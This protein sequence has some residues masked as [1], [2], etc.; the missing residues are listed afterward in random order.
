[1]LISIIAI[2]LSQSAPDASRLP[3]ALERSVLH[4]LRQ[5]ESGGHPDPA[6][7][8]GDNGR[9]I[10]PYQ[11]HREYWADALAYRPELGGTYQDCRSKA[12]AEQVILAYWD[13]YAT[14]AVRAYSRFH[15]LTPIAHAEILARIHNGG[16]AAMNNPKTFPYWLRVRRFLR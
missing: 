9:A 3:N 12:Y 15:T 13:R 11:I 8:I 5:V 14:K 16:P 7:A 4:S 10:G 1:M 2:V 6:N